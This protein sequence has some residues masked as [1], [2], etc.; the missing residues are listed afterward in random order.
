MKL[1]H[2][3]Y[4]AILGVGFAACSNDDATT[5]TAEKAKVNINISQS[6]LTADVESRATNQMPL[7]DANLMYNL[8]LLH[9]NSNQVLT[10]VQYDSSNPSLSQGLYETTWAPTLTLGED[11]YVVLLANVK[12]DN[13]GLE[14]KLKWE[15]KG[16]SLF[17]NLRDVMSTDLP[18]TDGSDGSYSSSKKMFMM[19]YY[20]GNISANMNLNVMMGRMVSCIK[21][22][23]TSSSTPTTITSVKINN[24]VM[25][26]YF[27]PASTSTNSLT[28]GSYTDNLT[29]N[30]VASSSSP[31]TLYYYTGENINPT[32]AHRT[33]ATISSS[34][35]TYTV[36]LGS[37]S[38]SV[39]SNRNYS[40]Y[41]NNTYTFTL[42]FKN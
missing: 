10:E 1:K 26:S 19:G 20:H 22:V 7:E 28:Y 37:D 40:L 39:T 23:F 35:G 4:I 18:L 13:D 34:K 30:N 38:P 6:G 21:L 36:V 29:S 32:E 3:L 11:D 25:S 42:N 27:F 16:A 33:T 8:I 9:Y 15:E 14:T 31:L 2:L 24:A 41:R 5:S 17:A 12:Q